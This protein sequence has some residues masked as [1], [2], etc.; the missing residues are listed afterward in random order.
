MMD[1]GEIGTMYRNGVRDYL[2]IIQLFFIVD[3]EEKA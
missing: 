1:V 2:F 3:M